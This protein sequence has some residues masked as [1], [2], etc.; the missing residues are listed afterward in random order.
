MRWAKAFFLFI[1]VGLTIWKA[2]I[3]VP[4][5]RET[6]RKNKQE[7]TALNRTEQKVILGNYWD[8]MRLAPFI[9]NEKLF[10]TTPTASHPEGIFTFSK[11]YPAAL[12]LGDLWDK[13]SKAL[14]IPASKS[15]ATEQLLR[16]FEVSYERNDLPSG[17]YVLYSNFSIELSPGFIEFMSSNLIKQYLAT[18]REA[19]SFIRQRVADIPGPYIQ[20]SLITVSNPFM[21]ELSSQEWRG[22]EP[23]DW[24][25]VLKKEDHQISFPL[26]FSVKRTRF[27]FPKSLAVEEGTYEKYIYFLNTPFFKCGNMD[28]HADIQDKK[29]IVSEMWDSLRFTPMRDEKRKNIRGLPLEQLVLKVL[30]S[31]LHTLECDVYSFF[32]FDST[33]WTNR[34]EQIVYVNNKE[35]VLT[36]GENRLTIPMNEERTFH[37][38]T[39]YRSLLLAKDSNGNVI[40]PNTGVVLERIKV[41]RDDSSFL[42]VPFLKKT[43]ED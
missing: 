19:V 30:D 6:H 17:R 26:N 13:T 43:P 15:E 28:I 35:Y 1:F 39:K 37:F 21:D 11:Y 18:E 14:L 25:Y 23:R 24:R 36:P 20:D 4:E 16:D 31:S 27:A 9:K 3:R 41:Y 7:I 8:V 2:A 34:Y 32:N 12:K 5:L 29:F 42:I 22:N 33:I 40:F 38:D 10:I